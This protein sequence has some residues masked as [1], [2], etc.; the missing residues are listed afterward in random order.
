[1]PEVG[2][3]TVS[4]RPTRVI[5]TAM[6]LLGAGLYA[7]AAAG[8]AAAGA[9]AWTTIGTVGLVQLLVAVRRKLRDADSA[10]A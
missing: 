9:G 3:V 8:W 10:E 5:V 7:D 2:V 6:F 4:E 1:M